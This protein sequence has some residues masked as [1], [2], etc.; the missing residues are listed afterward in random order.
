MKELQDVCFFFFNFFLAGAKSVLVKR[1]AKHL[2]KGKKNHI[3]IL[4]G[5]VQEVFEKKIIATK[6]AL[7]VRISNSYAKNFNSIDKFNQYVLILNVHVQLY[8]RYLY[9]VDYHHKYSS[10]KVCV[11]FGLLMTGMVNAWSAYASSLYPIEVTYQDYIKLVIE[12]LEASD[13]Q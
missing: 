1:L 7:H 9:Q 11:L 3:E 13:T 4:A 5:R 6:D 8:L 12:S 2:N 10:W